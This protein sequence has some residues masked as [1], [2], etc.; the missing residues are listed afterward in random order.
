VR[1]K[2]V[3]KIITIV[4]LII[5]LALISFV[6]IYKKGLNKYVN[7]LPEYLLGMDF[8]GSRVVRFNIDTGTKTVYYDQ[9]GNVVEKDEEEDTVAE[10]LREEEI[11]INPEEV[12]NEKNYKLVKEIIKK[13]L[14][15]AGIEE[16]MIRQ[17]ENGYF[18][19]ELAEDQNTDI[20]VQIIESQGI[21]HMEDEETKEILMDNTD[22]E[23]T[24]VVYD[25]TETGTAVYL[26][27][28]FKK[29]SAKKLEEISKIYTQTEDEEGNEITKNVHIT[30]DDE[31]IM[32][33]Y[34]GQTMST[35]QLQMP[36]GESTTSREV[37]STYVKQAGMIST[38]INNGS[39]PIKY[40][41]EYN[42]FVQSYLTEDYMKAIMIVAVI[43]LLT[44]I[45]YLIAEY[46]IN[47]LL[48]GI[49]FVGFLA[50]LMLVIRFTDCVITINGLVAILS[51]AVYNYIF[52]ISLLRKTKK[53]NNMKEIFKKTWIDFLMI[54]TPLY[55][56]SIVFSFA[57][58]LPISSF[59]IIL[60]WG[61]VV[62]IIYNIGITNQ[63]L[64]SRENQN[65]R[66][67]K[68]DTKK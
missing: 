23:Q 3:L 67:A 39:F 52:L 10:G 62:F 22:I 16:Y 61:S 68:N 2:N 26:I 49:S 6:G 43:V 54:G 27:I 28:D 12:L 29:D 4:L 50:L 53:E 7:I 56:V 51:I 38:I 31:T 32:D 48:S 37:L 20:A 5:L 30:L 9:D 21:F 35:G 66:R 15:G 42:N 60:F 64:L 33:T 41:V 34:F 44:M 45:T 17:D 14:Q 18:S 8:T 57:T 47:G 40:N 63:L 36:I 59:G 24:R 13:R 11:V 19:I 46:R 55:I 58:W 65:Y 1:N 25:T